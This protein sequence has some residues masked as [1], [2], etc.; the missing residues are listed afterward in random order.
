MGPFGQ[1]PVAKP[2]VS[3]MCFARMDT[4]ARGEISGMMK[5]GMRREDMKAGMAR[6][7]IVKLVKK[8]AAHGVRRHDAVS[9]LT[10]WAVLRVERWG[11][12]GRRKLISICCRKEPKHKPLKA[13]FNCAGVTTRS[14]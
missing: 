8:K 6:E 12:G 7:D 9:R 11:R 2:F 4:F 13:K 5:A 10:V 14:C 3:A 1:S